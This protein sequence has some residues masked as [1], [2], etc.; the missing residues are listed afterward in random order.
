MNIKTSGLKDLGSNGTEGNKT[1]TVKRFIDKD[2][3]F[4]GRYAAGVFAT[5]REIYRPYLLLVLLAFAG[6]MIARFLLLLTTNMLGLWADNLACRNGMGAHSSCEKI[7][8][9][10]VAFTD[11]DFVLSI[12]IMLV[13]GFIINVAF[14]VTIARVGI[15]AVSTLYDKTTRN[16]SRQPMTFFDRTPVGR[17]LS[18]FSGDYGALFRMAG[19]PMGEFLCQIFDLIL[20]FACMWLAS[21]YFLPFLFLTLVTNLWIYSHNRSRLRE[22]RRRVS[23]TR[24]P[25]IAHFSETVQGSGTIR[26]FGRGDHFLSRF[27]RLVEGAMVQR[28]RSATALHY[29]TFQMGGVVSLLLLVT[30]L[31]G[32]IFSS[33]QLVS[34]GEIA[35]ALSFVMV[36]SSTV[37]NFFDYI[38]NMEEAL[39]G[40]ERLDEYLRRP[41]EHGAVV[42]PAPELSFSGCMKNAGEV[43]SKGKQTDLPENA[44][45]EFY[46]VSLRYGDDLPWVLRNVTFSVKAGEHIGVIGRTGSGKSTL[47]QSLFLLYPLAGGYVSVNGYLPDFLKERS[48]DGRSCDLE[49]YRDYFSLIPQDP[50]VIR[51]TLRRNLLIDMSLEDSRLLEILETV[52]LGDWIASLGDSPLDFMIGEAGMNLSAG[53][54]QL[55]CMARCLLQ[56]RP[57]LVLDEATS[58]IDPQSEERIAHAT[59]QIFAKKTQIIVA[60]RLSTIQSCDRILWL[61]QGR[62]RDF[63]IPDEV[64][65][66]FRRSNPG[67]QI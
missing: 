32:I 6:G 62:V 67:V 40:V 58:S 65:P 56:N 31:C 44:P 8:S 50:M 23:V 26:I 10:L 54:R 5:I 66:N 9:Y 16:I 51:D 55:L 11:K 60:H 34:V 17:I 30:G 42:P 3:E 59:S 53:Q 18:R 7:P 28:I 52:G 46:D 22:E 25:A 14:R 20:I 61:D 64:L 57:V 27:D 48:K 36:T 4:Y 2:R 43:I 39:T 24:A 49:R 41:V 33:F 63:G 13:I 35:V 38:A 37:Q 15:L 21:P 1:S 29:F 19:G 45:V 12:A 47:L